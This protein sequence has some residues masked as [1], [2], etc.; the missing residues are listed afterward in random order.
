MK[1][2]FSKPS[3]I[4]ENEQ[5]RIERL[6]QYCIVDTSTD[7]TFDN[8]TSIAA[9]LFD[10]PGAFV[11]FVDSDR[12]FFKSNLSSFP[13]NQ[14]LREDSLCSIAIHENELSIIN[15]THLYDD[16]R[17]NPYISCDGGIRF[18]A[19][20]PIRTEDGY[21]IGT[22]CVIDSK[23]RE[24]VSELQ[25]SVLQKLADVVL[26]KLE[27]MKAKRRI[28]KI[29]N[30]RLHHMVHNILNPLTSI[31]ISAQQI[32]R[33]TTEGDLIY[34]LANTI[35]EN[36]RSTEQNLSKMLSSA[37]SEEKYIELE[38]TSINP[39]E[40]IHEICTNLGQI[41]SNKQ[42]HITVDV[43]TISSIKAD[44][45]RLI[46]ILTNYVSNA[47][48][49][50]PSGSEISVACRE[51]GDSV[52]F[53]VKDKGQGILR[54]EIDLLFTKFSNLSSVP[55]ANE[56]SH[57]FGLYSVKILAEMHNGRVWAESEG[58]GKGSTFFLQLPK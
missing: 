50:S 32:Q 54:S 34:R 45:H 52:I 29:A 10:A 24:E 51:Y 13:T 1:K 39:K 15:D 17:Q 12:V 57:G 16:L 11:N 35:V 19:S 4:P 33:K 9:E 40:V 49:Y 27:S 22:V 8:I 43:S 36:T 14:V 25:R 47:S 55:T 3:L 7:G 2:Y 26:D 37:A 56:R 48:K 5:E 20:A 23:P 28:A 21:N 44:R 18:Y 30:D 53:S 46:D 6:H 31:V 38:I 41:L 42:Q 58:R